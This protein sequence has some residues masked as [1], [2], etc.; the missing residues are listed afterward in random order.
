MYGGGGVREKKN[1]CGGGLR[2]FF[3]S[4]PPEDFKWNS[5]NEHPLNPHRL[6]N[7]DSICRRIAYFS[8]TKGSYLEVVSVREVILLLPEMPI[9]FSRNYSFR[10]PKHIKR[11]VRSAPVKRGI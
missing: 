11:S 3:Q 6:I 10:F 7:I 4:V 1:V 2:D 9:F 5:P 8:L